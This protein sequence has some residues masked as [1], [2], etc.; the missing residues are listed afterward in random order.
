MQILV[1]KNCG[2]IVGKISD[3][4]YEAKENINID[5]FKSERIFNG[6]KFVFI[7]HFL[8]RNLASKEARRLKESG[9]AVKIITIK[10]DP[11]IFELFA[12]TEIH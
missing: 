12:C 7:D 4:S 11:K 5:R 10:G 6:K 2:T 9:W 1:R 3:R 8:S